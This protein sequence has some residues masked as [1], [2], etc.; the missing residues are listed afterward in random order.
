VQRVIIINTNQLCPAQEPQCR[1]LLPI[2]NN[3]QTA[4]QLLESLEDIARD[5]QILSLGPIQPPRMAAEPIFGRYQYQQ[6]GPLQAADLAVDGHEQIPQVDMQA[7]GN[8][9]QPDGPQNKRRRTSRPKGQAPARRSN[10]LAGRPPADPLL[11]APEVVL[12]IA[13]EVLV[14]I[15][16]ALQ[17]VAPVVVAPAVVVADLDD[18]P[19]FMHVEPPLDQSTE[20]ESM[21]VEQQQEEPV[22]NALLLTRRQQRQLAATDGWKAFLTPL[23]G[24]VPEGTLGPRRAARVC[25]AKNK[26]LAVALRPNLCDK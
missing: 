4:A 24:D 22:V 10:R 9:Q 21:E 26:Y 25:R 17:V 7:E 8:E 11:V 13:H 1:P 2:R 3:R 15:A 23:P 20:D 12:A 16:E 18:A 5:M 14:P 19:N 6:E